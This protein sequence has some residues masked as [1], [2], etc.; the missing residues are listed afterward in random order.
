MARFTATLLL[1]TP[2]FPLVTAMT[3]APAACPI[4]VRNCWAWSNKTVMFSFPFGVQD[5]ACMFFNYNTD[6]RAEART[7][8]SWVANHF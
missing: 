2:P 5:L 8:V 7:P 4:I 6:M 3:F 1:P